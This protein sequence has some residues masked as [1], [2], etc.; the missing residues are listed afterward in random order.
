M[1][2]E[3]MAEK[4]EF[5]ITDYSNNG[6]LAKFEKELLILEKAQNM[7]GILAFCNKLFD[8]CT[9]YLKLTYNFH[10]PKVFLFFLNHKDFSEL[11]DNYNAVLGAI[12]RHRA[13]TVFTSYSSPKI[14]IDFQSHI[15]GHRPIESILALHGLHGRTDSCF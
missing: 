12:P 3:Y 6:R 7:E 5:V 4:Q 10:F 13:L 11:A 2:A 1:L 9:E 14:Y 15:A 8:D